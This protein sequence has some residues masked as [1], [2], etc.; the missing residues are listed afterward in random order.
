MLRIDKNSDIFENVLNIVFKGIKD[1]NLL[2][3]VQL[4]K[5]DLIKEFESYEERTTNGDGF[6][7]PTYKFSKK[8]NID[9]FVVGRLKH[10]ELS[11]LYSSYFVP[12]GLDSR[13]IYNAIL[14]SS[15]EGCPYCGGIGDVKEL[16]HF[17]PKSKYPQFSL[18]TSNLVPSC[19]ICNQDLKKS[20]FAK[21]YEE[22]IIHPYN[23][24]NIF[25]EDKWIDVAFKPN[26]EEKMEFF[27][28]PPDFW[29]EADKQRA[30]FHFDMFDLAERYSTF[31][32]GEYLN[33]KQSI[34]NLKLDH[35]NKS[36][37]DYIIQHVI[38]G[39]TNPNDCR[40]IL[41]EALKRE[42]L[43]PVPVS[44]VCTNSITCPRCRGDC[45]ISGKT[46]DLCKG[47]GTI[48][49]TIV[50]NQE[51]F[52]SADCPRC[53]LISLNLDCDICNGKGTISLDK[54]RNIGK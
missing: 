20:K 46:C 29:S 8:A 11:S 9:P 28:S 5:A 6:R 7:I 49:K 27:V 12:K 16:D 33:T 34:E 31:I 35:D 38:D 36:I 39:A 32:A 24:I 19:K 53:D 30:K 3:K 18:L 10:S 54:A 26:H 52:K 45:S 50:S 25:F 4:H 13:A 44:N 42:L 23:D 17:L 2:S 48:R 1:P 37:V 51:V 14:A 41:Y 47:M 40:K 43:Q 22:Q 15:I 21:L